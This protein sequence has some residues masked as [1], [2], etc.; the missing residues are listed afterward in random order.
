M[1]GLG[2]GCS[3]SLSE[4]KT[5]EPVSDVSKVEALINKMTLVEKLGQLNLLVGDMHNS[6][7]TL[8][9]DSSPR[10]NKLIQEGKVTG[11][12]Y[13]HGA[14]YTYELQRI[15]VE[16]SRLGIPLLFGADIIHGFKTVFPIPL[17][18]VASW[19][20]ELMEKTA[21]AAARESSAVGINWTFAP[22]V[23]LSRDARWGRIAEGAGEDP[24][25]ASR[26]AAARVKGYQGSDPVDD[27]TIAACIK[28]F[29]AYGAPVAGRDYNT[30]DMS[31]LE[32]HNQYLRPYKAGIQSGALSI[33]TAFN[34]LN[35]V[36][37]T[38]NDWLLQD[39]LR[40]EWSFDGMVVSDWKS[41][42]E[43][44]AHGSVSDEKDA[45]V[46][47]LRAGC[48]MDMMGLCYLEELPSAL[49]EGKINMQEIDAAVANVLN[50]K[51]RLGLFENPYK[52]SD[53]LRE[54]SDVRSEDHISLAR[55]MAKKSICLL[56]NEG[57]LLPLNKEKN[58]VAL[59]GPFASNKSEHNGMWSFFGEPGHVVSIEEALKSQLKYNEIGVAE[60]CDMFERNEDKLVEALELAKNSDIIVAALGEAAVQNG[61]AASRSNIC[62][63]DHQKEL[64]KKLNEIGKPV[65]LVLT[66]GRPMDLIWE[67]EN[68]D[69]ILACW[70][71]GSE[72]G[73]AI[74]D[75]ISGS[76][77]PSGKLPISFPR[78]VGQVPIYYNHKNTGRPYEGNNDEPASERVYI[79]KYRD[80]PNT[81]LYPFGYGLSYTNYV[82][83]DPQ[84]DKSNVLEGD[85]ITISV[86]ILNNGKFAGEECVQFYFRDTLAT[87]TRPV[88][89]LFGFEKVI[90][91]PGETKKVDLTLNTSDMGYYKPNGDYVVEPGGFKIYVG[92]NS[93]DLKEVGVI[94][95]LEARNEVNL[96]SLD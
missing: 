72:A 86:D 78:S 36:P 93:R 87:V 14:K 83:S 45:A 43:M 74:A 70:T 73:N 71:L 31:T 9:P 40:D 50:M 76:W 16:E 96:G 37:C 56:K 47:S 10:F 46:K 90:L 84:I 11:L 17:G 59:I 85:K 92:P 2:L 81:P 80:V 79:S 29:A 64:L 94:T 5:V 55:E 18:E 68:I 91:E 95:I 23:D 6:G 52:Y 26:V 57:Q 35:G 21:A 30:V 3:Q 66:H 41:A 33:M 19:D 58:K 60:G 54:Q 49:K 13:I 67:D 82:Y 75:V 8:I 69:A 61:E 44:I 25:L 88:L 51:Y 77:N 1:I 48:D 22:N 38:A 12:F 24:Y 89:E 20:I 27:H 4:S 39:I 28:H 62:I 32:L 7:P 65:V 34:E 53:T 63:P 42:T 15:A